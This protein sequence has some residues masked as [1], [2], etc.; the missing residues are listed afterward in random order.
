MQVAEARRERVMEEAEKY[1]SVKRV[2]ALPGMDEPQAIGRQADGNHLAP[3][4]PC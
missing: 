4:A 1:V 2:N 3:T